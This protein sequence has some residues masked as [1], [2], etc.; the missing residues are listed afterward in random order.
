MQ[1]ARATLD[2]RLV[3]PR[4]NPPPVGGGSQQPLKVLFVSHTYTLAFNQAKLAALARTGEVDVGLIAPRRW[5]SQDWGRLIEYEP[6]FKELHSYPSTAFFAGR[7]GGYFYPPVFVLNVLNEFRPDLIQIEQEAFSLSAFELSMISLRTRIPIVI[8]CWENVE[9]KLSSVRARMRGFVL[10]NAAQLIAGNRD[11]ASLARKWG[12][13]GPISVIPQLGVDP[14]LF[15]PAAVTDR[16]EQFTVGYIG[17]LVPEKGVDLVLRAAGLLRKKDFIPRLVICGRGPHENALVELARELGLDE[18]ITWLPPVSHSDV[19][20]V[21]ARLSVL[22]LPSRSAPMWREQFGQVLIEAMSMGIPVLGSSC[23]AIPEVLGRADLV[24]AE[25][26]HD[27]LASL[28]ERMFRREE[29]RREVAQYGRQRVVLHFTHN[30]VAEQLIVSW[31][32]LLTRKE[33]V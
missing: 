5:P 20:R 26:R 31:G 30:S 11:A 22:V 9:R 6:T 23:G 16:P 32:N 3:V 33:V 19:P 13:K 24:F 27:E 2:N 12:F 29:W 28:L 14:E 15:T 18:Q 7:P 10:S 21:L 25:G 17:R 4:S 8:F 1:S